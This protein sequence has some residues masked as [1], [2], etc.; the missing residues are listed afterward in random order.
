M[1]LRD[2]IGIALGGRRPIE[3][4]IAWAAAN[5]VRYV[6]CCLEAAGPAQPTPRPAAPP[7][8]GHQH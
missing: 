7:A 8:R 6:D 1:T 2:R 5:G 3:E 4:G